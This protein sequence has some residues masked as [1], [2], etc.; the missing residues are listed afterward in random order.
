MENLVHAPHHHNFV[1]HKKIRSVAAIR[2]SYTLSF[3]QL[4]LEPNLQFRRALKKPK[5]SRIVQPN[6]LEPF[7]QRIKYRSGYAGYG[8]F[9]SP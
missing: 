2:D 5:M 6:V 9:K 7:K 4:Q 8:D 1:I 3:A